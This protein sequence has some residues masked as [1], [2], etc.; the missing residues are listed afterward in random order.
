MVYYFPLKSILHVNNQNEKRRIDDLPLFHRL[1]SLLQPLILMSKLLVQEKSC[2]E[3]SN[4]SFF[5]YIVKQNRSIYIELDK[6]D[7]H[8]V[9]IISMRGIGQVIYYMESNK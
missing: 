1:S 4:T 5:Q 8:I 3:Q 6:I 7:M 9:N 2:K